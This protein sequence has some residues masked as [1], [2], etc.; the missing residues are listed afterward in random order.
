LLASWGVEFDSVDVQAQPSGWDELKRLGVPALP[1]VAVGDKAVHGWNPVEYAR[2][3]GVDWTPAPALIPAELAQRLDR[4]L[5]SAA[6]LVGT[7]SAE[8]MDF[9]PA[10]RQRTVRDLAYHLFR[11]SL[12]FTEGMDH[13]RQP[14]EWLGEKAPAEMRDGVAVASYGA[15]VRARLQGWF[16][17]TPSDEYARTIEVYYGP[18]SGHNLLERTTWH[19]A[20][21]LRQLYDLATRLNVT[22]PR[23]LPAADF[24]GLPLPDALW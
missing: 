1:A 23:P 9:V 14:R 17:A 6:A 10:E 18:Q 22:P 4:I 11:L 2:L 7:F 15:L 21:H 13:G 24:R 19:A 12:A 16:E 5:E 8:A 20:Q 3:L